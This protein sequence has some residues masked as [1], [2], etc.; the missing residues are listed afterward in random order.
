MRPTFHEIFIDLAFAVA[1]R[2]TC[3]RL[4]VGCVITSTD[5]R[6]VLAIGYNG[7]AA[8]LPNDCD[9]DEPGACGCL[10]AEDNAVVNCDAP[11]ETP[12]VV[13]VTDQPCKM[14]AK[15]LINLGNVT[16]V[17]YNRPYRCSAGLDTLKQAG[18][19]VGRI[20]RAN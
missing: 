5:F 15:R 14:C 20:T 11:R 8:G 7:N 9:S 16:H 2:S 4:Q 19:P 17:W 1:S 18:V 6:K 3:R 13:F 10:H 12:K